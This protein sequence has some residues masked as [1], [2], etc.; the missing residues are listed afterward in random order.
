MNPRQLTRTLF[1]S[2]LVLT[3]LFGSCQP[4]IGDEGFAVI[5]ELYKYDKSL[6]LNPILKERIKLKTYI[7]EEIYFTGVRERVG[8]YLAIPNKGEGP[9]PVVLLIDGM[10]GS[11]ERWWGRGNWSNG[12]ETTD[13][14]IE[15]G[16]AV[17]TIDA[18]MH[19]ERVDSSGIFPSPLSLRKDDLMRTAYRLIQ[20][21]AQDY[22]RALDYLETREEI[23]TNKAGAYGL[24]M[25]GA[26]T[27]I[28]TTLDDRIK[29]AVTGVAV[30]YGNE[31]SVVNSYNF[32]PR[33]IHKPFLMLMGDSDGY[34]TPETA[35]ELFN[36]IGSKD[37]ELI[38]FKGG[39]KIPPSYIPSI[40]DWFDKNLR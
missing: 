5:K 16:F 19:G 26:V 11:K 35:T 14:L 20:Q 10:G 3:S 2:S 30:V 40:A 22:M 27:F 15:K 32:T 31:Y 18:A 25:G 12:L 36:T 1:V 21:T 13:A 17:F 39:H 28:L 38:I 29:T 33:I 24:S 9:F 6:P 34:Y 8:A 37:K 7:R 4:S 23:N